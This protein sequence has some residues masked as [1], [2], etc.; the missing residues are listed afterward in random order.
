MWAVRAFCLEH[1]SAGLRS[2][3]FPAEHGYVIPGGNELSWLED[4]DILDFGYARE[5]LC[6]LVLRSKRSGVGQTLG[7]VER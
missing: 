3:A 6:D 4:E 1:L 5:P 2:R 7:A